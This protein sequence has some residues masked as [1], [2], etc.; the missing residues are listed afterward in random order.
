MVWKRSTRNGV[1]VLISTVHGW[2]TGPR[3]LAHPLP[4][5]RPTQLLLP[6]GWP[7]GGAE[8]TTAGHR[9]RVPNPVPTTFNSR[10]PSAMRRTDSSELV[11]GLLTA[12]EAG[13]NAS[14]GERCSVAVCSHDVEFPMV[15]VAPTPSDVHR[16]FIVISQCNTQKCNKENRDN[17]NGLWPLLIIACAQH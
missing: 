3:P 5:Q 12:L 6:I 1:D 7:T 14:Y 17:L 10:L 4:I 2:I 8:H 9:R 16:S 13:L 15:L 11:R